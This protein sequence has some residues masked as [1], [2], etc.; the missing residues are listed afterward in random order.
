MTLPLE[1]IL[2]TDASRV[3]AGPPATVTPADQVRHPVT[4]SDTLTTPHQEETR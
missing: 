3:L 1:G 2:I 4:R